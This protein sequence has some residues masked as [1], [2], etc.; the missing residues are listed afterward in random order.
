MAWSTRLHLAG[1][2]LIFFL[3]GTEGR[4]VDEGLLT[5]TNVD[6]G[7]LE[8]FEVSLLVSQFRYKI[9]WPYAAH[10]EHIVK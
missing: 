4:E 2:V 1:L 6:S 7:L 8:G 5:E 9:K 3:G 10:R